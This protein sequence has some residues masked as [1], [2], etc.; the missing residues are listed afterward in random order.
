[1]VM[2]S[3]WIQSLAAFLIGVAMFACSA[4][5]DEMKELQ[6]RF[7]SRFQAVQAAKSAGTIG[8]TYVGYLEAV[9]GAVPGEIQVLLD[10]ENADRLRLYTLIAGNEKVAPELVAARNAERNFRSARSGDWLKGRDNKWVQKP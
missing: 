4:R 10:Q 3:K 2:K 1:M 5:A 6:D 8:E 7:A 9:R